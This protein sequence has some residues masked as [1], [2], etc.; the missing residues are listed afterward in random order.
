LLDGT[1]PIHAI[2]NLYG[3]LA[4]LVVVPPLRQVVVL[5]QL[6]IAQERVL[7]AV[8][9]LKG[10]QVSVGL[11]RVGAGVAQQGPQLVI[12][13]ECGAGERARSPIVAVLLAGAEIGTLNYQ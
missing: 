2:D 6:Q 5:L 7:R 3:G 1:V 8:D 4:T 9:G 12:G 11:A 13:N 10:Q